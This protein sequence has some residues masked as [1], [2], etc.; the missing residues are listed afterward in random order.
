MINSHTCWRWKYGNS[1]ATS[2]IEM[3]I[4][5]DFSAVLLK[6]GGSFGERPGGCC[7]HR[8]VSVVDLNDFS[9]SDIMGSQVTI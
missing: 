4:G 7:S 6:S 2:E 5:T 9:P 3:E 1:G 8:F